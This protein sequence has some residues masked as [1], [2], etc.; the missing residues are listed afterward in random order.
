ML[1]VIVIV[2]GMVALVPQSLRASSFG[3]AITEPVGR[4]RVVLN[5]REAV[6]REQAERAGQAARARALSLYRV[7]RFAAIERQATT[8][9][10]DDTSRLGGR[11]VA[12]GTA[13]LERDLAEA[14]SLRA[15][16]ERVRGLR[17]LAPSPPVAAEVTATAS[18]T[19]GGTGVGT[20]AGSDIARGPAHPPRL[21]RPVGGP[22]TAPYGITRDPASGAW[23]FR[24]AVTLAA[25]PAESVRSPVAGQ[26]VRVARSLSG[27]E[28]VVLGTVAADAAD[29]DGW[30]VIVSGLT[31][32]TVGAGQTVRAGEVIGRVEAPR[33]EHAGTT[34]RASVRLE[35]WHGRAPVDP[36]ALLGR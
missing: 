12:L 32:A 14:R 6:L 26:V 23:L 18:V 11:A 36:T 22:V 17:E 24:S 7:L 3:D 8:L 1:S 21:V 29:T 2:T 19:V 28:A 31:G 9:T 5:A 4:G 20:V 34:A 25:R 27:G 16:W 15:E 30:S 33:G 35:V 13:V 10:V